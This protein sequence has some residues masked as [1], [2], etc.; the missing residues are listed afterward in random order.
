MRNC[1]Q[2]SLEGH[3]ETSSDQALLSPFYHY[4]KMKAYMRAGGGD[5]LPRGRLSPPPYHRQI[6]TMLIGTRYEKLFPLHSD[7]GYS[8]PPAT[9]LRGTL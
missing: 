9:E 4:I 8:V 3:S 6:F 7:P 2:Y 1:F 5:T